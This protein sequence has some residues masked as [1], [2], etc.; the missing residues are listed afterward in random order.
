MPGKGPPP[1]KRQ[2]RRHAITVHMK[3]IFDE[4]TL[5]LRTMEEQNNLFLNF[6][7]GLKKHENPKY[8]KYASYSLEYIPETDKHG[9]PNE[10]AGYLHIN[11]CLFWRKPVRLAQQYNEIGIPSA[12][13]S[14]VGNPHAV[15]DYC[16]ASGTKSDKEHLEIHEY[17]PDG[18]RPHAGIRSRQI[19]TDDMIQR[20]KSGQS[21]KQIWEQNPRIVAHFGIKKLREFMELQEFC[22]SVRQ[23]GR[24]T[25]FGALRDRATITQSPSRLYREGAVLHSERYRDRGASRSRDEEE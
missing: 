4:D 16:S 12:S 15:I 19:L 24:V 10:K 14:V 1:H 9:N 22:E 8:L 3:H 2:L 13:V 7:E 6:W 20:V 5:A 18:S 17:M 25:G 23:E 21:L 11:G